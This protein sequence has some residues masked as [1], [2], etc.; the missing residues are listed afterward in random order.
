MGADLLVQ[1]GSQIALFLGVPERVVSVTVI[2]IGTSL[3]ELITTLTA[4]A[5]RQ[6]ALSIG[7]IIGANIIDLALILPICSL[8]HGNALPVS[9]QVATIDLPACLFIGAIAVIPAL[10]TRN[11]NVGRGQYYFSYILDTFI[12]P[13]FLPIQ[14]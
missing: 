11:F 5:K 10:L 4:I 7:N 9:S 14:I 3:P 1:N 8:I 12:L 2:A 6:A 13:F